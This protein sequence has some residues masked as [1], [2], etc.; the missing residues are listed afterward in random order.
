ML[1]VSQKS[2]YA[3]L[4]FYLIILIHRNLTYMLQ[5]IKHFSVYYM[6]ST[7]IYTGFF[8]VNMILYTYV[9]CVKL[10]AEY[11]NLLFH[12]VFIVCLTVLDNK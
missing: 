4:R 10:V 8:N 12:A 2:K 5:M 3:V 9:C 11:V 7:S 6:E 1:I